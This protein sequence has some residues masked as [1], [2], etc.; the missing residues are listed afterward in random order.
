MRNCIVPA[1]AERIIILLLHNRSSVLRTLIGY[2]QHHPN[3]KLSPQWTALILVAYH[4]HYI[5]I[6]QAQPS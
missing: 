6:S 3:L 2:I 1:F 5:S 4:L